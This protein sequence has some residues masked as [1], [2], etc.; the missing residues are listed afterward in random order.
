MTLIV[1]IHDWRFF[2]SINVVNIFLLILYS[3]TLA[4]I[5][6]IS[7]ILT[8]RV[9]SF[10]LSS[11]SFNLTCDKRICK[12]YLIV[13]RS[14]SSGN[15]SVDV[16]RWSTWALWIKHGK[17][18]RLPLITDSLIIIVIFNHTH[19]RFLVI[20]CASII[21]T[22]TSLSRLVDKFILGHEAA[23]CCYNFFNVQK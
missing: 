6:W 11:I 3:L 5:I 7:N 12:T 10:R 2:T 21:H 14:M 9:F 17:H 18:S 8:S 13:C 15:F 1:N 23:D 4:S 19:H 22:E 20:H 16:R